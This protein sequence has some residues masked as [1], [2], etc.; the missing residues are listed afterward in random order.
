MG[1]RSKRSHNGQANT[2]KRAR[3]E[4]CA[5][6]DNLN[7]KVALETSGN[8]IELEIESECEFEELDLPDEELT[9]IQSLDTAPI[10]AL[11]MLRFSKDAGGHEIQERHNIEDIDR[12]RMALKS[13]FEYFKRPEKDNLEAVVLPKRTISKGN[14]F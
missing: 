11:T 7:A 10:D 5:E 4:S 8:E 9:T 12:E 14:D 2:K 6:P 13:L 3:K 1:R